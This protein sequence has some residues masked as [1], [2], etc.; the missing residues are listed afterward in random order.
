MRIASFMITAALVA[1][2]SGTAL[3]QSTT[4]QPTTNP[5]ATYTDD[6]VDGWFASAYLGSTFGGGGTSFFDNVVD[7][8][9]GSSAGL[10][11]GGEIGYAWNGA[12]GAEFMAN[13]SPNFEVEDRLFQRR[14]SINTYMVNLLAAVPIG[15]VGNFRP[16]VSGGVGSVQ[17]RSTIFT[18]DPA[19]TTLDVNALDTETATN[20]QFG[21]N[22]GGGLMAFN[23]AWGL[24]ADVRYF[25]ATSDDNL[26]DNTLRGA[27]LQRQLSG[28]SFW[29]ANFGIAFKW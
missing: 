27:L 6:S 7:I 17:M 18:I 3:A 2:L 20:S 10:N 26:T 16:F 5:S 4:S 28:L 9:R 23:G 22:L 29:N 1:G 12:F 24:R 25:A 13:H 19:L 15:N 8:D 11:L 21:W 14:P